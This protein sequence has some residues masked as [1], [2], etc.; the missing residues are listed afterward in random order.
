M[1]R[2]LRRV[3]LVACA[4][5][6]AAIRVVAADYRRLFIDHDTTAAADAL[7]TCVN[8]TALRLFNDGNRVGLICYRCDRLENEIIRRFMKDRAMVVSD[9]PLWIRNRRAVS[10]VIF[11]SETFAESRRHLL[12]MRRRKDDVH[13]HTTQYLFVSAA[14]RET[15]R[16]F[17]SDL[18]R[19]GFR[20]IA[21]LTL[22][23]AS[24]GARATVHVPAMNRTIVLRPVGHCSSSGWNDLD[25]VAPYSADFYRFCVRQPCTIFHGAVADDTVQ[26]WRGEDQLKLS[27]KRLNRACPKQGSTRR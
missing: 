3:S 17:A 16:V 19:A 20:D 7:F 2:S 9:R 11:A 14:A 4:V 15:V 21:F 8:R 25:R 27:G 1:S 23:A 26:F 24:G 12:T 13:L 22:N 18:W 5:V 10:Y 6:F